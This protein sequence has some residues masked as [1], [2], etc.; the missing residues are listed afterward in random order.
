MS[1]RSV[2]LLKKVKGSFELENANFRARNLLFNPVFTAATAL[3][4]DATLAANTLY[5]VTDTGDST[6]ALPAA[7]SSTKGDIIHLRYH[8]N[9]G[10]SN[11]HSYGTAGEFLGVQSSVLSSDNN[12]NGTVMNLC[13][14]PNGSSHDYLLLTGATNAGP[15]VGTTLEF[16]FDGDQWCVNGWLTSSGA[17][18]T[19][20]TVAY[21][22]TA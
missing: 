7:A 3:S 13:A 9:I 5:F 17:G 20:V 10:N 8:A 22:A 18:T 12:A 4:A 19:S 6:Y 15:G 21:S 1:K 16:W 2:N 11:V 14:G